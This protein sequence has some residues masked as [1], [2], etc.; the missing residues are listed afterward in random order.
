MR[1]SF[2]EENEM[3]EDKPIAFHAYEIL[4]KRGKPLHY[5]ELTKLIMKRKEIKGN[6]P[7]KTVNSA[8]CTNS[9]FKR[10]GKDRSGT[11]ALTEWEI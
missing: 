3:N 1:D 4:K 7:W 9:K 2:S 8:I 6:T 11:Y 5:L 10:I